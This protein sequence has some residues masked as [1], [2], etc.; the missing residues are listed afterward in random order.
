[1]D[2]FEAASDVIYHYT[3]LHSAAKILLNG[4]FELSS[5]IGSVEEQY[6]PPGYP[7]FLSTTRTLTGGYHSTIGSQAVMFNLDGRWINARYKARPVDYWGDRAMGTN[8][9]GRASEAEDRIYSKNP[10]MPIGGIT[11]IHVY[12]EPMDEKSRASWGESYPALARKILIA[13]K[14]RGIPAYLYEDAKAWRR[15]DISRSVP[16]NRE[17]TTLKG[18]EPTGYSRGR[19]TSWLDPWL[20]LIHKNKTQDLSKRAKDYAYDLIYSSYGI[21]DM[22]RSLSND[23]ANARKPSAGTDRTAAVSMISWMT[24]NKINTLKDFVA[25]MQQKW[26]AI[27]DRE[28]ATKELAENS[29]VN[30][31]Y[32][33]SMIELPVGTVLTP[34]DNYETN[35]GSTDFYA[36][37]EKY[38]PANMLSHRESVFMCDNDE[39]VDLAGGGTD[40]LFTVEPLGKIQRHDLNWGS[41]ISMLISDGYAVDSEEVRTAATNYWA[42]TP[43][44]NESVWE[45]LTPKA[46]IL[47][48]E[49]Y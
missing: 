8:Y 41:E 20:E 7:Y 32:H 15:Q 13:A 17:R 5:S 16:I 22:I 47:Q 42:G 39:D 3:S 40:W 2:L 9:A 18:K 31:F 46:K 28:S 12:V 23:F 36:V 34:R 38:R 43:H 21:N 30:T 26:T 25:A 10:S 4:T 19:T 33:G 24:A 27:K 48:V 6:A 49:E 35:W 1:M 44:Y 45:Y 14:K 29:Q 11:S 37:L